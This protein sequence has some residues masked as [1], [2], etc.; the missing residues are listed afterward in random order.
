MMATQQRNLTVLSENL[1]A[2]LH[3]LCILAGLDVPEHLLVPLLQVGARDARA[4]HP[5]ARRPA[6][7]RFRSCQWW[8]GASRGA[9]AADGP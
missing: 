8:Q 1:R 3:E 9:H 4:S 6:R 2:D 5:A 7:T